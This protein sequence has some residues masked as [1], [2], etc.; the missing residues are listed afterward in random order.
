[1]TTKKRFR[2]KPTGLALPIAVGALEEM[3]L[4]LVV[5]TVASV[6]TKAISLFIKEDL[7]QSCYLQMLVSQ[8][9][10]VSSCMVH[11]W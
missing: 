8:K 9:L 10:L 3:L 6:A 2:K 7:L 4:I 5:L 11:L 1:M